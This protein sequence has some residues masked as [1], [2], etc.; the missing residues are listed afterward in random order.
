VAPEGVLAL[1]LTP[2]GAGPDG[3]GVGDGGVVGVSRA[4]GVG[5]GAVTAGMSPL[6]GL[7]R[8]APFVLPGTAFCLEMGGAAA[9]CGLAGVAAG[10][11]GFPVGLLTKA[12]WLGVSCVGLLRIA[13]ACC[14]TAFGTAGV[15]PIGAPLAA[16]AAAAATGELP[17]AA[18]ADGA[19][20]W[21][22]TLLMTVVL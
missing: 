6:A 22:I 5:A 11:P 20:G 12:R 17:G 13:T 4:L 10:V 8:G 2:A 15:A 16:A 14:L 9:G 21:L 1:G 7:G 19:G 18:A 3:C